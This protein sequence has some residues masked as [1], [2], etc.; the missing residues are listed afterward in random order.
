V[1]KGDLQLPG[2]PHWSSLR[3]H[4]SAAGADPSLPSLPHL[5]IV[6]G[7]QDQRAVARAVNAPVREGRMVTQ[8]R[9]CSN[10]VLFPEVAAD[11]GVC[12]HAC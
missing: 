4:I 3:R 11:M 10:V 5:I 1:L 6:E 12:Y 7:D 8:V 2:G 9:T